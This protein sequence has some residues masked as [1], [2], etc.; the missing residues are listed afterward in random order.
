M[1]GQ[2]TQQS[3]TLGLVSLLA[4]GINA[5]VGVGIFF[6]PAQVARQVA[7][8]AGVAVYLLT[9]LALAP[10]A[11]AYATLGGRF[12]ED[13]GPYVWARAAFGP[14]VGFA[15]GWLTYVS[16]VFSAA[17]VISGLAGYVVPALHLPPSWG[18]PLVAASCVLLLS[19]L[20]ATGL[21]PSAIAWSL[22][23]VLKLVPLLALVALFLQSDVPG[24]LEALPARLSAV[25]VG[26]AALVVVFAVQGFEIVP[27]PAGNARR[28]H[29]TVPLATLASLGLASLLYLLLHAACVS[30]LPGLGLSPTPLVDTARVYGGRPAA[31]MVALGTGVSALG[32]AF[33]MFAMTPRY[34]AVLGHPQAFGTWIGVEDRRRHVPQRA[35]A[36]TAGS[37]LLLAV[38]TSLTELFV[39]SSVAVL[40]Q[41]AVTTTSLGVLA[42]RRERGLCRRQL[43]PAP[44]ALGAVSMLCWSAERRQLAMAATVVVL[45]LV[46][47]GVRRRLVRYR[48]AR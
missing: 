40:T 48:A 38:A 26:Q 4:L 10:I 22:V 37:V 25:Q 17:A 36:V 15:V 32:I 12:D 45:G 20:A 2:P 33:G 39:L 29:R 28:G 11:C 47:L 43:W 14:M 16:A 13:G 18:A 31:M 1:K 34:L 46:Y 44:L 35:L 5:I 21:R 3:R 7:G 42:W 19:G 30:A 41:Y 6:A 8:M 27:V 23:T 9:A 24:R